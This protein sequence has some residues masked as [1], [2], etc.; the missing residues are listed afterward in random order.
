MKKLV[1]LVILALFAASAS[2]QV[3]NRGVIVKDEGSQL[4]LARTVDFVGSS[5]SCGISG[6]AAT[7]TFTAP[8][9]TITHNSTATASCTGG[10]IF[11][12]TSS[13]A[14]CGAGLTYA[15]G[16]LT[17]GAN[18][19]SATAAVAGTEGVYL[20]YT[21][22]SIAGITTGTGQNYMRVGGGNLGIVFQ[23]RTAS[24]YYGIWDG[25]GLRIGDVVAPVA[26]LEVVGSGG[27]GLM[28]G[29]PTK[30]LTDNTIATFATQ[31]LG[32]DTGGCETI[33]Y[34]VYA[35]NAT[36][37]GSEGGMVTVCG[38]DVTAGAGGESCTA[39]AVFGNVQN[40]QGSTLAV[41]FAV[42]TGTDLC[43][44][45]VTADTDIATPTSL[46]IKWGALAG[47]RTLTPQ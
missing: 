9:V 43:N 2:A 27:L 28:A 45:R 4:G 30:N 21:N 39:S 14:D 5:V 8:T 29:V 1:C 18:G 13:L 36:T 40:L 20:F 15:G 26:K 47:G 11:R 44:I 3:S 17:V 10:G 34:T 16:A 37:A 23:N 35:G 31:T 24:T 42:S 12:S 7:C 46:F 22:T 19:S 32:N 33:W 6:G 38:T 25:T 41:T